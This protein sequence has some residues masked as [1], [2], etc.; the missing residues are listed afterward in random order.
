MYNINIRLLICIHL[1]VEVPLKHMR[2][3]GRMVTF[4]VQISPPTSGTSS[5]VKLLKT[6]KTHKRSD[7]ISQQSSCLTLITRPVYAVASL[8]GKFSLV[9]V[10]LG[11]GY[12]PDSRTNDQ[13]GSRYESSAAQ[14]PDTVA[15]VIQQN[16][17]Y[18][19]HTL[20]EYL[21]TKLIWLLSK[22]G[23]KKQ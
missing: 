11:Q 8:I 1:Y 9:G 10:V 6:R 21:P 5:S 2:I 15:N 7:F 3:I 4:L 13:K 19:R 17:Q 14:T 23:Q 16:I 18:S 22:M 20:S 12:Q